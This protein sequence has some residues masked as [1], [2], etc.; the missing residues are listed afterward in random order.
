V[1]LSQHRHTPWPIDV[2]CTKYGATQFI[3]ALSHFVAQY[4][5]PEYSKAQVEV[6]STSIH[7]PFLKIS[8]FHHL[9]FISYDVYGLNPLD[10]IMVDSIH[11][12]PVHFNKCR[13]VVPGR[14]D[15]V[16]VRVK[17]SDDGTSLNLKG[18]IFIFSPFI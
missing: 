8:I 16:V 4:Q 5:H 6:T 2:I 17:D 18:I 1:S 9:K 12:D 11:S 14:F 15:T 3:P 10:E 7:I 13:T